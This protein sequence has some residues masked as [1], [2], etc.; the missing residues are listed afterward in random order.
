MAWVAATFRLKP[1]TF[2]WYRGGARRLCEFDSLAT[3]RLDQITGEQVA[4]Y[5]ASRQTRGLNVTAI[6]RELQ[7]L[8]RILRLALE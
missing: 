2:V 1:N 8:R 3:A 6:N 4:A 5:V 7:I